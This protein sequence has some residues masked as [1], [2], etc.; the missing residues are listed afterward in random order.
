VL[1]QNDAIYIQITVATGWWWKPSVII[2]ILSSNGPADITRAH[3]RCGSPINKLL[4]DLCKPYSSEAFNH[5]VR[6]PK[7]SAENFPGARAVIDLPRTRVVA[8]S[9]PEAL[10][11]LSWPKPV[12]LSTTQARSPCPQCRQP[13]IIPETTTT[14]SSPNLWHCAPHTVVEP[15]TPWTPHRPRAHNTIVLSEPVTSLS[16]RRPRA[17]DTINSTPSSGP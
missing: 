2:V 5:T 9:S 13:R 1:H 12:T 3:C 11:Y 17:R 10:R 16:S 7:F 15:T 14:S 4:R 8:E 6:L